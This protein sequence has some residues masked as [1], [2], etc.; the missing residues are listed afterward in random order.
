MTMTAEA[1]ADRL[2]A[3]PTSP[4][5]YLMRNDAGDV[6]YVDSLSRPPRGAVQTGFDHRMA[7]ALSLIGLKAPGVRIKD[8][9]C[10][11]KTFPTYFEVLDTLRT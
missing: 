2:R 1:I 5:V 11:N 6:L 9:G 10:V 3:T 7:M 8:P 4:G